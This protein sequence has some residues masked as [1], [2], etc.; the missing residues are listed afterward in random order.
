MAEGASEIRL[1][2]WK[3]KTSLEEDPQ[4]I[5]DAEFLTREGAAD[6]RLSVYAIAPS[7][8]VRV[9]TEHFAGNGL[10]SIRNQKDGHLDLSTVFAG[11]E[12]VSPENEWFS[13]ARD[14]HR[15][16]VLPDEA[17]LMALIG[18]LTR[19]SRHP[20]LKADAKAYIKDRLDAEDEEWKRFVAVH[21]NGP[22]YKRLGGH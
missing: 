9:V 7:E 1:R 21:R 2:V 18:S 13:R 10:D 12:E 6:L 11:T 22:K 5:L 17:S 20:Y 3:R 14:A 19:C 4:T 8:V 15:E 16:L